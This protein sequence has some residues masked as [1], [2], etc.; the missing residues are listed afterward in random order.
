MPRKRYRLR[1][2]NS[3]KGVLAKTKRAV[4]NAAYEVKD[5]VQDAASYAKDNPIKTIGLSAL[6]GLLIAQIIR[7]RQLHRFR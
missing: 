4:S 7:Y 3:K 6:A 5:R 1:H 2:R